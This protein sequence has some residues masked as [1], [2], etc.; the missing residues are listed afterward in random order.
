LAVGAAPGSWDAPGVAVLLRRRSLLAAP[1]AASAGAVLGACGG[2]SW[3]QVGGG[4]LV[5]ATGNSGGVFDRYGTALAQ[6]LGD[7]LAPLTVTTRSTDAS[8]ANVRLVAEGSCGLGMT[9]ADTAADAVR[10]TGVFDAAVDVTALTRTYD[11][12]VHLVVRAGS[13][14]VDLTDLR[15]LR[16]GLGSVG[17][18]TRVLATRLLAQAGLSPDDVRGDART[19]EDAAQELRRQ[20]VDAFFFVSGIPNSTVAALAD[21]VPIRLVDLERWVPTMVERFGPEYVAGPIPAA[22]YALSRGTG[23][24][25]VKNFI[26]ADPGLSEDLGY[27]LTRVV[28]EHQEEIDRVAPGVPQPV[29]TAAPFT[30]PVPLHPGAVRYFRETQA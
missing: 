15:G 27:A 1:L 26:L 23:T 11:S 21:E 4:S 14:V 9:L 8:V 10:G 7:R 2:S 13:P 30:S 6:V 17:S 18:G 24:V 3:Q 16:V 28:F 29:V 5:L 22:T 25:S 12:F 20:R 19:L